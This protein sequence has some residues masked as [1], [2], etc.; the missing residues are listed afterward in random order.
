[1]GVESILFC[2]VVLNWYWKKYVEDLGFSTE[3]FTNRPPS[4]SGILKIP[5]AIGGPLELSKSPREMGDLGKDPFQKSES[6]IEDSNNWCPKT[7]NNLTKL[8]AVQTPDL[9]RGGSLFTTLKIRLK[10]A[11]AEILKYI[12]TMVFCITFSLNLELKLIKK[13]SL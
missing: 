11:F 4:P 2:L 9:D 7:P 3:I 8:R 1:M 10:P 12:F 5:R 6:S 13:K